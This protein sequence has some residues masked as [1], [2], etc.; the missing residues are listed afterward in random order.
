MDRHVRAAKDES[1]ALI[2]ATHD[3]FVITR[4]D[5]GG[6]AVRAV[7]LLRE[8]VAS[9]MA[10]RVPTVLILLAAATI[11]TLAAAATSG[12]GAALQAPVGAA[13]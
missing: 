10:A 8:A 1:V 7:S 12:H 13:P 4:V 2:I 9:A 6:R 3:P 5:R 11:L